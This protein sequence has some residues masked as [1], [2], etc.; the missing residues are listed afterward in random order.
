M[1]SDRQVQVADLAKKV[2]EFPD[3]KANEEAVVSF[4]SVN[5]KTVVFCQ[6]ATGVWGDKILI[7]LKD[8]LSVEA[9]IEKQTDE[10]VKKL[11]HNAILTLIGIKLL[12]EQFSENSKEWKLVGCKAI[13]YLKKIGMNQANIDS[14]I[15]KI[16]MPLAF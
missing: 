7:L 3:I 5:Y 9:L 10:D 14:L 11:N 13:A 12:K 6:Q 1:I 15:A 4:I 8:I 2:S 16:Y